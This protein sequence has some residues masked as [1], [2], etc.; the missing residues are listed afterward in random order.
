MNYTLTRK[1]NMKN[2]VLRVKE[3]TV[4]VS[5]PPGVSR[6]EIDK[7]I[8]TKTGWI[9]KQLEKAPAENPLTKQ[10][11]DKLCIEKFNQTAE[12][13]YS[14]IQDRLP[15][16]P[17]IFV[18]NYKSRWGVCYYKRGYI[19]LNKQLYDKPDSAIEYVILHEYVHFIERGHGRKFHEIMAALMPD[20]KKRKKQLYG[21]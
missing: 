9:Q 4:C 15:F 11:D 19:I 1:R 2:I 5:A 10:Y 3:G 21:E 12:N 17:L 6:R 18:K 7:F 20:Y 13:I 14:L 8:R 16:K